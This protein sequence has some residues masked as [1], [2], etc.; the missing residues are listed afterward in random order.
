MSITEIERILED[1]EMA[2]RIPSERGGIRFGSKE[3]ED[4]AAL[5]AK[6][7]DR[8][9]RGSVRPLSDEQVA[10]LRRYWDRI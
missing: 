7:N 2:A 8:I 1:V 6:F 4:L 9:K 10:K 3:R 5:R